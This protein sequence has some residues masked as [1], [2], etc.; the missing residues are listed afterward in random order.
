MIPGT[1]DLFCDRVYVV[2]VH[3]FRIVVHVP[4]LLVFCINVQDLLA[5]LFV[6]IPL[7]I[8]LMYKRLE[9]LLLVVFLLSAL[10]KRHNILWVGHFL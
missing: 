9:H 10:P 5:D 6:L 3:L 1:D 7:E 8:S 4:V 2:L